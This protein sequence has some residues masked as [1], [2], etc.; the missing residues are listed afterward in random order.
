MCTISCFHVLNVY[1]YSF[2]VRIIYH[3]CKPMVT[4]CD[5]SLSVT[6]KCDLSLGVTRV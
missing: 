2:S 3:L 1:G 4:V 5:W 6:I